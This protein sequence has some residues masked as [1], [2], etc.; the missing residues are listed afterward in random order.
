MSA[1]APCVFAWGWWQGEDVEAK[2]VC[3]SAAATPI[4]GGFGFSGV[5]DGDRLRVLGSRTGYV[6]DDAAVESVT[7]AACGFEHAVCAAAGGDDVHELLGWGWNAHAQAAP[8]HAEA[9]VAAPRLALRVPHAV[10]KVACG[11]Q[12]TLAL[13]AD[14][15]VLSW[16]AGSCGQ[17]GHG[18]RA[19]GNTP[20]RVPLPAGASDIAAG[21]RHSLAACAG[22]AFAWGWGLYGQ[23]GNGGNEDV[24]A[25]AVVAALR[26]IPVGGVASG[27]QHSVFVTTTGDAY[28]AGANADGQL[29]LGTDDAAAL[30]PQLV[31]GVDGVRSASCGARHTIFLTADGLYAAGWNAHGQLCTG[32]RDS[33]RA[34]T[35]VAGLAG[36]ATAAAAGWWHTLLRV[37]VA[38]AS[39]GASA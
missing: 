38:A 3:G 20:R 6:A 34:P 14:G 23:L 17:L 22:E 8:G 13:L 32:D 18:E 27:M 35:R 24:L 16:G 31:E 37:S 36:Q 10:R 4:A 39:G 12:H 15:A 5:L 29:G 30:T 1:G 9:E 2:Q 25:P 19:A 28:A 26:G 21:A 11:E 7:A 33:R